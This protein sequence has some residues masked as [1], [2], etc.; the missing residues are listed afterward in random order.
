MRQ[1]NALLL[2]DDGMSACDVGRVLYLDVETIRLWLKRFVSEG[3]ASLELKDYRQ[4]EG[5]LT[6][7]Q[8]TVLKAHLTAR[9][10]RSTN[11]VREYIRRT[12]E[13][14]FSRSGAIKFMARLGFGYRIP[15]PLPA[16]TDEASQEK[17]IWEYESLLN[18]LPE[19]KTVVLPCENGGTSATLAMHGVPYDKT[20]KT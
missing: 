1:A 5:Y 11:E 10:P 14:D 7:A 20:S 18:S 4:H 12:Y 3:H 15:V 17:F 6:R 19:D 2:P 9:P 8:E 13:Q 16:V